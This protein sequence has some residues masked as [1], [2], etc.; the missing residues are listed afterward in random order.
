MPYI[1]VW[2]NGSTS[3]NLT[4]APARAYSLV[5]TD[6]LG[7]SAAF[8]DNV[9]A[10]NFSATISAQ[11]D[12]VILNG[13]QVTLAVNGSG[14]VS[15]IWQPIVS[16][17]DSSGLSVTAAPATTTIY[18]ATIAS[19]VA[20]KTTA[21]I[22]IIVKPKPQFSRPET[23]MNSPTNGNIISKELNLNTTRIKSCRNS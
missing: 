12:S 22:T 9:P 20:C 10:E 23:F 2:S 14:A 4:N 19:D 11:P 15:A 18:Q 8:S 5:V 21:S 3:Q 17:N 7:C 13:D 6:N 16:F 1:Y